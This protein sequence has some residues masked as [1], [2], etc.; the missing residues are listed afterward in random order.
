MPAETHDPPHATGSAAP[1]LQWHV[2][3]EGR[4]SPI[5][6]R[7]AMYVL[8]KGHRVLAFERTSGRR[9]WEAH[10][11]TAGNEN[12]GARV[13]LGRD[14]V[15][16]GDYDLIAFDRRTGER[17]WTFVPSQGYGPGL[18]L[19]ATDEATVFAGSP[20]GRAYAINVR[21]GT[22]LWSTAIA[23]YQSASTIAF[24]PV[25]HDQFVLVRFTTFGR[26][27]S[28][29]VAA[30]ERATGRPLW[31]WQL[32][33]PDEATFESASA[34]GPIV[35]DELVIVARS[36]GALYALDVDSGQERWSTGAHPR[37]AAALPVQDFRAMAAAHD[38]FV[39]GSL[40]GTVTGY[41]AGTTEAAWQFTAD[42]GS[43]GF[44][45]GANA[46]SIFVPFL[47]GVLVALDPQ[48]G[49]EQWRVGDWRA[50]FTS[51]PA[52]FDD[53]VYLSSDSTGFYAYCE[54]DQ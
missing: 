43:A 25:A 7:S 50:G 10:T 12:P 16:A 36:D 34:G 20:A 1:V 9:L 37:S 19:G 39:A 24:P 26:S 29:G 35:V 17:R 21:T 2:R 49:R 18:Y 46:R 13:V 11:G 47:S 15:I 31:R 6:D 14:V 40:M 54:K 23:G 28:G 30:V 42:E 27:L 51:P 45:I 44:S 33:Q 38:G 52:V 48:S 4:G 8:A 3:G 32:P 22:Q 5:V 53:C 41:L